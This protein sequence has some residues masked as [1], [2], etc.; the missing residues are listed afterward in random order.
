MCSF[1]RGE[2]WSGTELHEFSV[3][4]QG[5]GRR[6]RGKGGGQGYEWEAVGGGHGF[7]H[8]RLKSIHLLFKLSQ[9]EYL[10]DFTLPTCK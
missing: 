9:K 2:V 6:M 5:E 10:L 3:N 1:R 8:K 4:L 7:G